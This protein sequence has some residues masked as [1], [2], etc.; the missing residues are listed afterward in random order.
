MNMTKGLFGGSNASDRFSS[1]LV[2]WDLAGFFYGKHL[3]QSGKSAEQGAVGDV[4]A[5]S[6]SNSHF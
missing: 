2:L 1:E 6:T 5:A 4:S 3:F